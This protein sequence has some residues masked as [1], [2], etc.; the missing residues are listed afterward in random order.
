MAFE[1]TLLERIALCEDESQYQLGINPEKAVD[2][3]LSHLRNMLNV[4][5]GSV[6]TLPDYGLPDINDLVTR[7]PQAI[8]EL[9][10]CIKECIERYEPRL[11]DIQVEHVPD[12]DNPLNLRYD[13]TAQLVIDEKRTKV[14]FET[15]L[16]S[17]GRATIRG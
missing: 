8:L 4:R 1:R 16:D 2:S 6:P 3:V 5:Q 11:A 14:W 9:K 10:K 12:E 13:I 17:A 7:F 15:V